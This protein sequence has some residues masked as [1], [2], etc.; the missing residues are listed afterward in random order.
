MKALT[1]AGCL[2]SLL[3]A[4]PVWTWAAEDQLKEI[5]QEQTKARNEEKAKALQRQEQIEILKRDRENVEAQRQLDQVKERKIEPGQPSQPK[6]GEVQRQL[7][8]QRND[9]Q[10]QRLQTDQQINRIQREP[11][12]VRQQQQLNDLQRQQQIKSLQDQIRRNQNQQDLDRLRQPQN[13]R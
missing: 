7:D 1:R 11:D 10:L 13:L 4:A 9:E 2:A 8:Q 5:L 3:L 6:A 12:P